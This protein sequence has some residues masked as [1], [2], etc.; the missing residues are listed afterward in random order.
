MV[1]EAFLEVNSV[2]EMRLKFYFDIY[3]DN[4]S[5][6]ELPLG[7]PIYKVL[8]TVGKL[9]PRLSRATNKNKQK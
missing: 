9:K 4:F 5:K 6:C 2:A 8:M 3:Y 1:I 7:S